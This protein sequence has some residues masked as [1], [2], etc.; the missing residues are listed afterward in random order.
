[1]ARSDG[2]LFSLRILLDAAASDVG[3][4]LAE[5]LVGCAPPAWPVEEERVLDTVIFPVSPEWH[6]ESTL[7]KEPDKLQATLDA[8]RRELGGICSL[9]LRPYY[10]HELRADAKGE[11]PDAVTGSPEPRVLSLEDG[12][13]EG[14]GFT[15]TTDFGHESHVVSFEEGPDGTC[16]SVQDERN[17][18]IVVSSPLFKQ[19]LLLEREEAGEGDESGDCCESAGGDCGDGL[20]DFDALD[21]QDEAFLHC[22]CHARPITPGRTELIRRVLRGSAMEYAACG[23]QIHEGLNVVNVERVAYAL[24]METRCWLACRGFPVVE[25]WR[26]SRVADPWSS[27]VGLLIVQSYHLASG[28]A[29]AAASDAHGPGHFDRDYA[30]LLHGLLSEQALQVCKDAKVQALSQQFAAGNV[31][32]ESFAAMLGRVC[33]RAAPAADIFREFVDLGAGPGLAVF[34]AHA[35]FP[36][37]RVLGIELVEKSFQLSQRLLA[38]YHESAEACYPEHPDC[39]LM[40]GDFLKDLDWSGAS[41]V[42]A[43]SVTWPVSLI[44]RVARLALRLQCGAVFMSLGRPFPIDDEELLQGFDLRG[45]GCRCTFSPNV[46]VV[47]AYQRI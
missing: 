19:G 41:V 8:T 40:Q 21:R 33:G 38:R 22:T 12:L 3:A 36:F 25:I 34:A 18:R 24:E 9:G 32:I 6:T 13:D 39:V 20:L 29:G 1:M 26:G 44:R 5:A 14:G 46:N 35:L 27:R 4:A 43:N 11:G 16:E 28:H 47:W 10:L 31:C 17:F 2:E 15:V 23:K 42:F 37:R 45:E 30:K 7:M